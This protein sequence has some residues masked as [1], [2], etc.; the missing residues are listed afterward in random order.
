MTKLLLVVGC[1]SIGERHLRCFLKTGRAQLTACDTN[2]ALLQEIQQ[3]HQVP[4][5]AN[6]PGARAS[7]RRLGYLHAGSHAYRHCVAGIGTH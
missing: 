7:F 1:G 3:E 5:F 6:L 4:R 2:P